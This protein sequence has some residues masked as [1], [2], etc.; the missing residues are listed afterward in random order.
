MPQQ[1]EPTVWAL[2]AGEVGPVIDLGFG[3]HIV[4]VAERQYAGLKPFD[5]PCQADVRNKLR[6]QIADREFKRIVD[7][8]KK[9]ATVVVYQ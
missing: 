4:R 3:L 8:L 6:N 5:V 9:K 7:E 2:K 1:V